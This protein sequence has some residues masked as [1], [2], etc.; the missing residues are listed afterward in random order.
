MKKTKQG[1]NKVDN[2]FFHKTPRT[3]LEKWIDSVVPK[4]ITIYGL[5]KIT[6]AYSTV[7]MNTARHIDENGE[8]LFRIDYKRP[9]K[10]AALEIHPGAQEL[11]DNKEMDILLHAVTHEIAHIVTEPLAYIARTRHATRKDI[12]DS[13]EE[14]TETVAQIGREL[15]KVKYPEL[16]KN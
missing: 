12:E 6:M 2:S 4:I 11:W 16:F 1:K 10:M 7:S 9:Y 13:S 15:L 3:D 5:G 8:G 14:T